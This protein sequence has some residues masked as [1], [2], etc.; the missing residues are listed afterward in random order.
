MKYSFD[1]E[2]DMKKF[3]SEYLEQ[4]K[5]QMLFFVNEVEKLNSD[6]YEY[7]VSD[8]SEHKDGILDFYL[9]IPRFFVDVTIT[10]KMTN[11]TRVCRV[12]EMPQNYGISIWF[13]ANRDQ[14]DFGVSECLHDCWMRGKSEVEFAEWSTEQNK[15][16]S[17][18]NC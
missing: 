14:K 6:Y 10:N 5:Q 9:V 2:E 8:L 7:R 13:S 4:L 3:R 1:N 12:H 16:R 11:E 17:I 15:I 18:W